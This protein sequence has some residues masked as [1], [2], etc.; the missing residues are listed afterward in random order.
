MFVSFQW[1]PQIPVLMTSS[2]DHGWIVA[3]NGRKGCIDTIAFLAQRPFHGQFVPFRMNSKERSWQIAIRGVLIDN[4]QRG[5]DG[6]SLAAYCG[7]EE[8]GWF[9]LAVCR[10]LI[11]EGFYSL[12]LRGAKRKREAVLCSRFAGC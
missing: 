4:G 6:D 11:A 7:G 8:G 12:Y 5:G 3:H 9:V 2:N 1:R 10:L